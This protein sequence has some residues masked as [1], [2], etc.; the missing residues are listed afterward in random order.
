MNAGQ[1]SMSFAPG[2]SD[3]SDSLLCP[4]MSDLLPDDLARFRRIET[5]FRAVCAR[6]GYRE[7]RTPS[8]EHL[9][10]FTSSGTLSPALLGRADSFLEWDGSTG[11]GGVLR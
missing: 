11:E 8:L 5:A 2:A 6:W 1:P 4:G 10:L 3:P 7:L 9:Y